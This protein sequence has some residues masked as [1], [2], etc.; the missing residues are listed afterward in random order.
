MQNSKVYSADIS[1]ITVV[2]I[3]KIVSPYWWY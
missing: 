1:A 2:F 3:V